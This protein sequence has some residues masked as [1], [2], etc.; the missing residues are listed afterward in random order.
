MRDLQCQNLDECRRGVPPH[1][2][3]GD[4]G[5]IAGKSLERNNK[6][7]E[8]IVAQSGSDFL[9]RYHRAKYVLDVPIEN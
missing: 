4:K 7:D 9:A 6:D 2:Q 5:E 3:S 8:I 1:H